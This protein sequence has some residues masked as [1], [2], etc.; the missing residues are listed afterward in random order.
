MSMIPDALK[1]WYVAEINSA[2][3]GH[4]VAPVEEMVMSNIG[5]YL[6]SKRSEWIV[7]GFAP[8]SLAASDLIQQLRTRKTG[9]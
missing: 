3:G 5:L 1:G 8:N 4:H 2:N 6:E 7:V 9:K